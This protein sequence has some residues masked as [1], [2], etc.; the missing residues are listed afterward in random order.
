MPVVKE[1]MK[2]VGA[3]ED[4]AEE[5]VKRRQLIGCGHRWRERPRAEDGVVVCRVCVELIRRRRFQTSCAERRRTPHG[6][7]QRVAIGLKLA[8]QQRPPLCR[9]SNQIPRPVRLQGL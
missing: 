5:A 3:R 7:K 6:S 1:D 4:D 8:N 2:L 9:I